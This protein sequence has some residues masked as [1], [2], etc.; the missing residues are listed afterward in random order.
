MA[1]GVFLDQMDVLPTPGGHVMQDSHAMDSSTEDQNPN[2]LRQ[3][4]L[5]HEAPLGRI[6]ASTGDMDETGKRTV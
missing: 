1:K 3:W 2:P 5:K 4:L 6:K